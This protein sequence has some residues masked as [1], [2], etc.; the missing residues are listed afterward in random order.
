MPSPLVVI[1][2]YNERENLAAIVGRVLMAE[3]AVAVLVVD[4]ASPD[5]T[6]AL[7]DELAAADER[8][9]VRHRAGKEGLG[10]AYLDAFAWALE[11]GYDPIVQMDADGSHL[12]EQL[13][14]LLAPLREGADLVI[15]SRWIPGGRIE[16]WPRYRE[17]LSRGGSAYARWVLR[18]PTRDAT[19][20]YR[21]FRAE[22]LRRMRLD[23]VH[24]K[25]Y[26]FQVDMLWH[27]HEAGLDVVEVPVTF[28]ERELGRS[29]MSLGIVLEAMLRVTGWGV[30]ARFRRR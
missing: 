7:A 18:L 10:A 1:P 21:A 29:K 4:D 5:G 22:G 3:P 13:G 6:G 12:P 17:L 9:L 28:V 26:G 30:A 11:A 24:T 16:N 15:G 8:V 19:A 27:A 25:G 2:T 20:G 14:G 23:E